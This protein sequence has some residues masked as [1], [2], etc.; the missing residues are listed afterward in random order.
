[1]TGPAEQLD[2]VLIQQIEE[3]CCGESVHLRANLVG[4]YRSAVEEYLRTGDQGYKSIAEEAY[5]EL[6]ILLARLRQEKAAF[7]RWE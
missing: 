6:R 2:E 7:I 5:V 3:L 1:M 4:A